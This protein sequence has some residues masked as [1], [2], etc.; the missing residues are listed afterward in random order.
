MSY[1]NGKQG[2]GAAKA[3]KG[4]LRDEA[5]ERQALTPAHHRKAFRLGPVPST[6]VRTDRSIRQYRDAFHAEHGV[7]PEI[8]IDNIDNPNAI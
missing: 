2:K 8:E 6:G 7:I 1:F 4:V 5:V 3:R